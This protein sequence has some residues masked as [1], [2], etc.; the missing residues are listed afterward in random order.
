MM[1]E[2]CPRNFQKISDIGKEGRRIVLDVKPL[3][4]PNWQMERRIFDWILDRK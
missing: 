3:K 1:K 4:R 2:N